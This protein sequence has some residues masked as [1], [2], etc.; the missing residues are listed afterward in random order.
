[1]RKLLIALF[2]MLVLAF[3]AIGVSKANNG[4]GE[5]ITPTEP[6]Q[7]SINIQF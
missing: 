5:V 6:D 3:G 4:S 7:D 1:M 2:L